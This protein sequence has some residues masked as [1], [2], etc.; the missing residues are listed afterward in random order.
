MSN[1]LLVCELLSGRNG[2]GRKLPAIKTGRVS[3]AHRRG[4]S[5]ESHRSDLDEGEDRGRRAGEV[6]A[7]D[8]DGALGEVEDRRYVNAIVQTHPRKEPAYYDPHHHEQPD[9]DKSIGC[10]YSDQHASK[11]EK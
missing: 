11:S 6:A 5:G 10:C 9:P 8:A 1:A 4:V 7:F 2:P 3:G